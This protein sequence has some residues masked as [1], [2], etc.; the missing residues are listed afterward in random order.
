M[1]TMSDRLSALRYNLQQ[2]IHE[3]QGDKRDRGRDA[4]TIK[5]AQECLQ[6]VDALESGEND[7]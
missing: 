2:I 3:N 7:E 4:Q 5:R 1:R 6:I